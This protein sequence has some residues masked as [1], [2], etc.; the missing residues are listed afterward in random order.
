[1]TW[2]P[3]RYLAFS[4]QRTR[5]AIDLLA[6]VPL[7]QA[8]VIADLGCGPGNSTR[9][10]VERWPAAKVIGIDSSSAMLASARRSGVGATWVEADIATWAPDRALDLIYSNAALHWIGSHDILLPRLLDGVRSGGVLAVQMP[11]NFE[12]PSHALLRAAAASGP[13]A[14]RL[15]GVLNWMP[16]AAPERYYDLL[17]PQAGVLDIWETVYLHALE[18][19]D[20]VLRWTRGTALRPIMQALDANDGAAFEAAYA[21]RLR[22]AYPRRED[23]RTL[24]PFRRLFIVAQRS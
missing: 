12:A 22:E 19:D 16:V 7:Q 24:F 13:W 14:D 15:A 3:E 2:N 18:G 20:A 4:D 17:A 9:L 8:D 23:G 1:M 10:L 11:R 21:A 6:R 5:P